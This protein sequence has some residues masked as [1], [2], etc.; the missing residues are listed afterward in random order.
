MKFFLECP[1]CN[2]FLKPVSA[3]TSN[4]HWRC[5]KK[6][7]NKVYKM[8]SLGGPPASRTLVEGQNPTSI[9]ESLFLPVLDFWQGEPDSVLMSFSTLMMV[10]EAAQRK[11]PF[12][13]YERDRISEL[14]ASNIKVVCRLADLYDYDVEIRGNELAIKT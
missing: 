13:E 3:V 9:G 4:Q 14:I 11:V 5:T 1:A 12:A 8:L 6:A 7:C 2:Y 10:N